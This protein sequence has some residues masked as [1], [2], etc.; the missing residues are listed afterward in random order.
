[1]KLQHLTAYWLRI[2]CVKKLAQ[3]VKMAK[4]GSDAGL[5]FGDEY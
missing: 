5:I 4:G 2:I 3:L 1:M